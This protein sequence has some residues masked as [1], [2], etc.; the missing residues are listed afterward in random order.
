[1]T[2]LL[3]L[4]GEQPMPILLPDRYVKPERSIL[5][6]TRKPEVEA[7][8]RR[9]HKMISHSELLLVDPY[10][11]DTIYEKMAA[12]SHSNDVLVNLTGGTKMMALAAFS[13][14]NQRSDHFCY[15]E[16]EKHRSVL[17]R[18]QFVDAKPT[19]IAQE[20]LPDLITAADY[21][22]AY[23]PGFREDG[24]SQNPN[25]GG[26]FEATVKRAL[27]SQQFEVR[28]EGVADQIEIDLV[29]RAQNQVGIAEVKLGG[30][31]SPK[32]GIDQL[33]TAG[34]REYL[35]TYTAK[36]LIVAGQLKAEIRTLAHEKQVTVIELPT[37]RQGR[38]LPKQEVD[39]LTQTVREKLLGVKR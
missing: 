34:S 30:E 10:N 36:F 14:V 39:R 37:Y 3:S 9:L 24:V 8:A 15:F 20:T 25:G 33:S 12:L 13:H 29:I 21:L 4:V 18:Y 19:R 26:D 32:Q 7:V 27:E 17:T 28:P 11:F 6:Y 22:N 16:S 2:T 35:G 31:K 1:M 23:L 38:P 5:V